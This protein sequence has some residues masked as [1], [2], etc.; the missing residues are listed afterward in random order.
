VSD[1]DPLILGI[2]STCDETGVGLV[3]GNDLLVDRTATSM[4]QYARFGG[5]I[6]EIASRAHL[7]SFVPTLDAALDEVG[8]SLSD[9]DAIAVSAG[10]GLVGSLTVGICAAK[11]LALSLDR[12]LYGVNHVIGHLAVD[13]LVD[14]L[15]PEHFI[16]LVVSG[17]HSSL[18][19]IRDI[20]TDVRELGGTLDD[21]AGEAFDKVGR[22][23]DTPYP[24]GPHIDRMSREGDRNAIRFPRGLAA[25][26]D[27]DRH[28]YDFSF[29]GLKTA[30]A[31]YVEGAH[32]RGETI[33][34]E[35]VA[36]GFSEA[37]ND[38]LTA[39][40]VRA[41]VDTGCS[42]IVIGGGF[43]ANSRLRDLITERAE[44]AGLTVRMPPLRFCTDNGAQIAA[45]GSEL[46]HAGVAPSD[47]DFSPDSGMP[48]TQT[49][50]APRQVAEVA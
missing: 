24:G 20:A 50:L 7:E 42:T 15:L 10:P 17:G 29:S 3:R 39:K 40:A 21:A 6:P 16:G 14:G 5:I 2:E 25:A 26:K 18:L 27:H 33:N 30:V 41:A 46:V 12:P 11:A 23:L 47:W 31:R 43:S 49:W 8:L 37:V 48:L 4:D 36:A 45:M 38:S 44:A 1:D 9:V 35:D 13:K 32:D 19:E 22:L 34:R 28:A